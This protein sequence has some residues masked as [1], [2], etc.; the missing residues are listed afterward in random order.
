MKRS[1]RL[2]PQELQRRAFLSMLGAGI[3]GGIGGFL[4]AE[5]DPLLTR[6]G[7]SL[8][9]IAAFALAVTGAILALRVVDI[10]LL[11]DESGVRRRSLLTLIAGLLLSLLACVLLS[12]DGTD[13]LTKTVGALAEGLLMTGIGASLAGFLSVLWVFGGARAG[14]KME[15]M[16]DEDW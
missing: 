12:L 13:S 9:R 1:R 6:S 16:N 15:R 3:V 5:P 2:G 11:F 4:T 10:L 14:E 8:I 7:G